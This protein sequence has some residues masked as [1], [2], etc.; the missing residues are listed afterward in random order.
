[1]NLGKEWI[2]ISLNKVLESYD[3]VDFI[4][5]GFQNIYKNRFYSTIDD[6]YNQ[7]VLSKSLAD[8]VWKRTYTDEGGMDF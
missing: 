5:D 8:H 1:M 3:V 6:L 7:M 4:E 2:K